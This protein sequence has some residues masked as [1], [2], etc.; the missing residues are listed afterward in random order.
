MKEFVIED[1]KTEFNSSIAVLVAIRDLLNDCHDYSRLATVNGYNLKALKMWRNSIKRLYIEV[2][3]KIKDTDRRKIKGL[4]NKLK[5]TGSILGTHNTPDQ[6][7]VSHIIPKKFEK[8]YEILE[9][10]E[11]LIRD[12]ADQ[13][14]M[15]LTEGK[16]PRFALGR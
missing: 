10:I 12:L 14:G 7:K 5:K 16:D 15:L 6:G 13:K 11:C 3:P 9:E 2:R 1:T 4:F 8:Y